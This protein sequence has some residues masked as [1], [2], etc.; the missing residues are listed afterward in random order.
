[1]RA[2][3]RVV[4]AP[5]FCAE[6]RCIEA[7][8]DTAYIMKE[9]PEAIVQALDGVD[10]VVTIVRAMKEFAHPGSKGV[11]APTTGAGIPREHSGPDFRSVLHHQR[12]G[13]GTGHGLAIARSVVGRHKGRPDS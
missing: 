7:E 6:F 11:A 10:R 8:M 2:F 1:M 4:F 13:R 5:E 3:P 12:S 9:I